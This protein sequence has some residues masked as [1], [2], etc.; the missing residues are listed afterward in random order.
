MRALMLA[1]SVVSCSALAWGPTV[2]AGPTATISTLRSS[3]AV[4]AGPMVR[5]GLELGEF[6]NHEVSLEAMQLPRFDEPGVAHALSARYA[7]SVDFLGKEGFTPTLG[8][9]VSGGRFFV[10]TRVQ[11]AGGWAFSAFA[12]AGVRYTFD[13]GL[14]L[15]LELQAGLYALGLWSAT[16]SLTAAWRF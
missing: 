16:P 9:G 5:V 7:F 6:F 2:T 14:S 1:V 3:T 11:E 8:L 4:Y 12:T 15:K 10:T 13:V